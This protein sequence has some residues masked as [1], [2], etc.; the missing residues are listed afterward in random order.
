[1]NNIELLKNYL[2]EDGRLITVI[3]FTGGKYLCSYSNGMN[4]YLT[5]DQ[6]FEQKKEIKIVEPEYFEE[7][8][9][10][11][12]DLGI[13][14]DLLFSVEEAKKELEHVSIEEKEE[15]ED[16]FFKDFL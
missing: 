11:E 3:S 8:I 9:F 1:M 13:N 16:D 12:E 10:D 5:K 2:D 14:S 6:I 15:P 7:Q 4:V